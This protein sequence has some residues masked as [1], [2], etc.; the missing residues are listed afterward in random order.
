[1][2]QSPSTCTTPGLAYPW[3]AI[4]QPSSCSLGVRPKVARARKSQLEIADRLPRALHHQP[5][6]I[7]Q[8]GQGK[9]H[10]GDKLGGDI[11]RQMVLPWAK[12]AGDGQTLLLLPQGHG[13][14]ALP[15]L[16]HQGPQGALGQ[17]ARHSHRGL[18]PQ[19]PCH[20]QEKAQG[21]PALSTVQQTGSHRFC[22][23][24]WDHLIAL[25]LAPELCPQPFQAPDRG[26]NILGDLGADHPGGPVCQ[27]R[28]D[29]K[30]VGRRLG[31]NGGHGPRS[32]SRLYGDVHR[33]SPLSIHAG[34]SDTGIRTSWLAPQAMGTTREMV[35]P[36]RFLSDRVFSY[37][38]WAE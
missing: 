11:S 18:G 17:A 9:E 5:A 37:S 6:A 22:P 3:E 2:D 29:Q 8:Q 35:S 1:M 19:G 12:L 30:A 38:A 10:P 25:P 15:Q 33:P 34:S 24:Q 14:A 4:V 31:G 20:R 16:L 26:R 32:R 23:V 27:S 36:D 13:T 28:A 7:R 21:G